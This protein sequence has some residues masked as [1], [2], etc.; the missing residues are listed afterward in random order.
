MSW[1]MSLLHSLI[2]VMSLEIGMWPKPDQRD[3]V[4]GLWFEIFRKENQ[5][6]T[7]VVNL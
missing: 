3:V 2:T 7:V 4:L 6:S 1:S 5:I